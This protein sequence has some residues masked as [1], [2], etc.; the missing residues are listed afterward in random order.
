MAKAEVRSI[1]G[2][3][4]V[5][6]DGR[7]YPFTQTATVRTHT[8]EGILFDEEYFKGMGEA[9]IKLFYITCDTEWGTPG[10]VGLFAEECRR[11]LAVIPDAYICLLY[12]SP[13]PRD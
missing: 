10:S 7:C 1:N 5:Y 13:S 4:A 11:L 2:C 8:P 9:G 3:P 6:I 12:T